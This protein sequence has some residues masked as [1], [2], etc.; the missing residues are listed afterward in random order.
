MKKY[1]R[2]SGPIFFILFIFLII[3][4]IFLTLDLKKTYCVLEY[5]DPSL[6]VKK[7]SINIPEE[8]EIS[9]SYNTQNTVYK[10]LFLP[11]DEYI[12][13]EYTRE[14]IQSIYFT[15][16][17]Q[18]LIPEEYTLDEIRMLCTMVYGECGAISGD[19]SV[20]FY[21]GYNIVETVKMPAQYMHSLCAMVLLNRIKDDRFPNTIYANLV[22]P[23]QYNI[24]YTY[25]SQSRE[26]LT[27]IGSNWTNVVD[28]VILCLTGEFTIPEN[29]I[30]Q[31]NYSNLGKSY[32]ATIYVDTG[33]FRSMSYY[34][35]G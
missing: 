28:D 18:K 34:A 29:V 27:G 2:Y 20:S 5:R 11:H 8:I 7:E 1:I 17:Q 26:Y 33:Y 10:S 21:D 15:D 4:I 9:S 35:Y 22:K 16:E 31:S 23:N 12:E 25:E 13:E 24:V 6:I 19:V 30:F 3:G 14:I 32:Y